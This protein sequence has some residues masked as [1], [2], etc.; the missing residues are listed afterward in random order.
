MFK[1]KKSSIDIEMSLSKP[2]K[3]Q[4]WNHQTRI[5][6]NAENMYQ[7]PYPNCYNNIDPLRMVDD[8]YYLHLLI[9]TSI[10]RPSI[11]TGR[12]CFCRMF[13]KPIN[14]KLRWMVSQFACNTRVIVDVSS[15]PPVFN[16]K[17]LVSIYQV[18]KQTLHHHQS[19]KW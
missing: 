15:N 19:L 18:K 6:Y 12:I 2:P 10:K 17:T 9:F 1:K 4:N 7:K 14:L 5:F 3:F 13:R 16:V 8:T 11:S